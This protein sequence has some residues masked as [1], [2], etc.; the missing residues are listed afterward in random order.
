MGKEAQRKEGLQDVTTVLHCNR[1]WIRLFKKGN[2]CCKQARTGLNTTE[3]KTVIKKNTYYY[4]LLFFIIQNV[5]MNT[6]QHIH[7]VGV[8]K[9]LI[10]RHTHE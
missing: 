4:L 9:Y 7:V 6:V 10:T 2:S 5:R 8:V 1:N 3:I